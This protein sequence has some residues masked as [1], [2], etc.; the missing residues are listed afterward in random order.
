LFL[1]EISKIDQRPEI[2][3]AMQLNGYEKALKI[4][5][6]P[7]DI[8]SYHGSQQDIGRGHTMQEPK[9]DACRE[10]APFGLDYPTK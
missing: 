4:V 1:D 8:E 7:T 10:D 5:I 9:Q 6:E 2:I 3:D